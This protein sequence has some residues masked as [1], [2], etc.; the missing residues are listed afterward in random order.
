MRNKMITLCPT[1]YELAQK[2]T[3]FSSWVRRK[4][5]EDRGMGTIT[6]PDRE[7]L[8]KCC[9][10]FVMASWKPLIDGTFAWVGDCTCGSLI[11]WREK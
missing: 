1:S 9:E 7:M 4:L 2:M 3:N 11:T 8:T 5:L 6:R 10:E